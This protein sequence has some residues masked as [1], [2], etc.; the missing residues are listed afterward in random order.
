[1]L[2]VIRR[3]GRAAGT[4]GGM[5][6]GQV[7]D[8]EAEG[9]SVSAAELEAIHRSKT[10]ALLGSSLWIGAYL[11]EAPAA[12][13]DEISKFCGHIGLA[14]QIIDDI[15]DETDGRDRDHKKATY[16][17]VHGIQKSRE[18]AG[19]LM[20]GARTS[21]RK[22]GARAQLLSEFCDYLEHRSQ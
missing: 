4:S 13:L 1:M 9:I 2:H 18:L 16:P 8:L 3:L 22:L 10:G 5:I 12:E 6:A 15:L 7:L 14:F 20:L 11:G 19:Q 21:I 17:S